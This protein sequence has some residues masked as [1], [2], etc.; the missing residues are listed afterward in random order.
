[1]PVILVI[2]KKFKEFFEGFL[3]KKIRILKQFEGFYKDNLRS[4]KEG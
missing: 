3:P 4:F 2:L 1:M